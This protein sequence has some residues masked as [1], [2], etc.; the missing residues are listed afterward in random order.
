[1]ASDFG[2][3]FGGLVKVVRRDFVPLALLQLIYL[4]AWAVIGTLFGIAVARR[5]GPDVLDVMDGTVT[6][7]ATRTEIMSSFT[8]DDVAAVLAMVAVALLVGLL[9]TAWISAASTFVIVRKAAGHP[10]KMSAALRFAAGRMFPLFGWSLACFV[11]G[12]PGL[13]LFFVPVGW[14]LTVI[15]WVY[16]LTVFAATLFGVVVVERAGIG[17]CFALVHPRFFPTLG[18]LL[19][20]AVADIVYVV[21]VMLILGGLGLANGPSA[22]D[23][24][25]QLVAWV[26]AIPASVALVAASVVTYAE[27]R[28]HQHGNTTSATLAAELAR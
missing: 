24:V 20:V 26:L 9:M 7:P 3:W 6:D 28:G 22:A 15:L 2:G 13:A 10:A 16:L 4:L 25:G 19:I 1:M 12:L 17:R 14:L 11:M 27:L 23:P 8:G 5:V 21:V 18:R